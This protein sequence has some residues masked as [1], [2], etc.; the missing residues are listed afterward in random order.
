MTL[1]FQYGHV[2][3]LVDAPPDEWFIIKQILTLPDPDWKRKKRFI[4][5]STW[6]GMHH[7]YLEEPRS[8]PT[9]LLE[10]V[11]SRLE[12][13]EIEFETVGRPVVR[14][15]TEPVPKK[16][17]PFELRAYQRVG[18]RKAVCAGRGVLRMPPRS[19]KTVTH[20]ALCE[21]LGFPSL[22]L[23]QSLH[24]LK[25]HYELFK[26]LGVTD[27]G[28]IGEGLKETKHQHL[29][30]T[31]QTLGRAANLGK[32]WALGVLN[33]TKVIVVDEC[34]NSSSKLYMDILEGTNAP[35]R[36]GLSGTPFRALNQ[37]F[38]PKDWWLVGST[39]PLIYD[40]S[41]AYLRELGY[42]AQP[43]LYMLPIEKK[44]HLPN[45][46][47]FASFYKF[48]VTA[49]PGRNKAVVNI[50]RWLV[51]HKRKVLVLV[52]KILHGK[53]LLTMLDEAGVRSAFTFGGK[54]ALF[55]VRGSFRHGHYDKALIE[56]F[57]SRDIEALIASTVMDEGV[58]FPYLDAVVIAGA[59]RSSIRA[60]QRAFRGMTTFVGKTDTLIFDF[61]DAS[62]WVLKSQSEARKRAYE[63]EEIEVID[64][65]PEGYRP[66]ST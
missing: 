10:H 32:R 47:A 44:L 51:D 38:N 62:A 23:V 61:F 16:I 41:S 19:G 43:K 59:G 15:F 34:H 1:R 11:E 36:F 17:G 8:F 18:I 50:V 45:E 6:D 21:Y 58:D 27:V 56:R 31:V 7:F 30:A 25:Q 14:K 57:Q 49:N 26:S 2:R 29:I 24:L 42:L 39:G 64:G 48:G 54:R 33:R 3:V 37:A 20:I 55:P 35:Y 9:G 4:P 46:A 63:A 40:V 5:E 53:T 13:D 12:E 66:H 60:I 28:R 65:Y 22:L 52:S